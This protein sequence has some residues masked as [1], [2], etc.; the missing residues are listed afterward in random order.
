MQIATWLHTSRESSLI[1]HELCV[2]EIELNRAG[3]CIRRLE[4]TMSVEAV[5]ACIATLV[6]T[7]PRIHRPLNHR[8]DLSLENSVVSEER[9]S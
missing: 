1:F 8:L 2:E 5:K 3:R 4:E 7:L 6:F 9:G